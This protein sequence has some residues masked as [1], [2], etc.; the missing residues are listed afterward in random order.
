MSIANLAM[1]TGNIGRP[2]TGANSITGQCNA[3]GSRLWGNATNLFG[4][5]QFENEADR[6]KIAETLNID[7]D[8][9]PTTASWPYDRI[10]EGVR[11]GEIRGLWVIAT[12][13]SH[14]W[15]DHT[16]A[17]EL[18]E[19]LDFLVVQDMY[20]T[21]DTA[22]QADLILPAAGWGEKEGTLINS[23]RR[24]GVLK[25]LRR[26]PGEALA[27]FQIF[28]AIAK[29]WGVAEMF[30][31]WTSPEAVFRIMQQASRG[32]FCDITGIEGY[33]QL[34]RCGGIQW[35]WS[36]EDAALTSEPE[37]QRRLF[38][39]GKFPTPSGRAYLIV[40][41][42]AKN[43]EPVCDEYPFVLLTG[44]GTVSQWHTQTR[45][46]KSPVLRKLYPNEVYV[47]IHPLDAAQLFIGHNALVSIASRR[48]SMTARACITSTVQRGQVF[49]PMH[50][51][52]V[53]RLTLAHF[54]P[55]SRQPSYKDCAVKIE[56]KSK[57]SA[58]GKEPS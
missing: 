51:D 29:Y 33:D 3:M 35:P 4:H 11:S 45:T 13:P 41:P 43:P 30:A 14:S 1:L 23:E 27:D 57:M 28:R 37:Q 6:E 21:T 44:R 42:P 20:T 5:H 9:I 10:L 34:D 2:G 16:D 12:N 8:L 24:Y 18:F 38:A 40:E 52:T 55:H 49:L 53:N 47:E 36:E 15:I 25:R 39:D 7:V 17:R 56:L 50:Y 31:N 32:Q 19:K 54:D 22:R 58:I 26:A 48:G 46:A